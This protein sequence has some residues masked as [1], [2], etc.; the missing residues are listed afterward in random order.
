MALLIDD[1]VEFSS[2]KK[3]AFETE[4]KLLESVQLFDVYQGKGIPKGKK[5]Y[6]LTFTIS[7]HTKTLT[8]KQVDKITSKIFNRYQKEF[9]AE[10]R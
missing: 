6:G 5:S 7:D 9:E 1:A 4:K 8:D 2:L 10:L 3:M